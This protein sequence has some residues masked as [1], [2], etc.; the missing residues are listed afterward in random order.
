MEL[1]LDVPTG[2]QIREQT[3][4]IIQ[5]DLKDIGIKVNLEPRE[6][7]AVMEKVVG[8]HEFELY[9]MGNTLDADPDPT[10]YWRSTQASDE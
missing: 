1:A 2:D 3:G 6:F 10:P 9:L 8:N 5:N 7:E 4:T